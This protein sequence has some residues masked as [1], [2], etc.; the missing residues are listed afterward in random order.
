MSEKKMEP[1]SLIKPC[2]IAYNKEEIIIKYAAYLQASG[3]KEDMYFFLMF[4]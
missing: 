1:K 4:D 2:A 3:F